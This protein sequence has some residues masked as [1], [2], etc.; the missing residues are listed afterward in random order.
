[1]PSM[2]VP[3]YFVDIEITSSD[4]TQCGMFLRK[5]P[6]KHI[7]IVSQFKLHVVL[8]DITNHFVIKHSLNS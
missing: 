2:T 1:M 7:K 8:V 5:V 6:L 3:N 4:I